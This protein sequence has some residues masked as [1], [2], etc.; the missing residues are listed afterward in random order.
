MRIYH[1]HYVHTGEDFNRMWSFLRRDYAARK[2]SFLWSHGRLGDWK[3]GIWNETKADLNFFRQHA[4]LWLD[5][6]GEV[7]GFV[8]DED[9]DNRIFILA[10]RSFEALY[11]SMLDW[12]VEHWLPRH[13]TLR[14]EV[15]EDQAQLLALLAERGFKPLGEVATTRAYDLTH[16]FYPAP[17]ALPPGFRFVDM[18]EN[19][20]YAGKAELY[21]DGFEGQDAVREHDLAR[22]GYSRQNPAYDSTLDFS[23]I[24][25]TG[26]H[27][28]T[29]VAFRGP[30]NR[31]A[32]VEKVCVRREYRRQGLGAAVIQACLERLA[33]RGFK[34]AYLTGYS[35]EANAL[36]EK[37]FPAAR[38][39]WRQF[40]LENPAAEKQPAVQE[41]PAAKEETAVKEV[42]AAEE[43]PAA[44][45][46]PAAEGA[47]EEAPAAPEV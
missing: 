4:E 19:G 40:E 14:V 41:Q 18:A 20:D 11:P 26:L 33:E 28:A 3:F 25:D 30:G 9:G 39:V 43:Q 38:K 21:L 46:Q 5:A 7:Q 10:S 44:K 23:V 15:H 47:Q 22:F 34:R 1:R 27:A 24:S 35:D 2:D 45:E 16:N 17:P 13:P 36:Y 29:C 8:I 12:A 37:L 6:Y 31:V 42:P 32:E